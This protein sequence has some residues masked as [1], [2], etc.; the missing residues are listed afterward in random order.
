MLKNLRLCT[1]DPLGVFFP[2]INAEEIG[3]TFEEDLLDSL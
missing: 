2:E 1:Y 3:D